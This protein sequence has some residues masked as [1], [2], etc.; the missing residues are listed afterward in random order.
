[1]FICPCGVS[2]CNPVKH[3]AGVMDI[4][5][6]RDK[7]PP[8]L[9]L[10]SKQARNIQ[11]WSASFHPEDV[12]DMLISN[13]KL[14]LYSIVLQPKRSCSIIL[15]LYEMCPQ[16]QN[17]SVAIFFHMSVEHP[18]ACVIIYHMLRKLTLWN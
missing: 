4:V 10:K 15:L 1:M 9:E 3:T 2:V 6:Q 5:V 8:S 14:C 11:K 17:S 13:I 18:V 12:S 7:S 16:S